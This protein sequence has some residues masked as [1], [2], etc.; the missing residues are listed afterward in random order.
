MITVFPQVFM[1]K[2]FQFCKLLCCAVL[3]RLVVFDSVTPCTIAHQAPLSMGSLKARILEWVGMPSSRGSSQPRNQTQVSHIADRFFTIWVTREAL[4]NFYSIQIDAYFQVGLQS[5]GLTDGV[6]FT[7]RCLGTQY[8][9]LNSY[10]LPTSVSL[11]SEHI[12]PSEAFLFFYHMQP[13]HLLCSISG[14][15]S[16]CPCCHQISAFCPREK[17]H[18]RSSIQEPELQMPPKNAWG[19]ERVILNLSFEAIHILTFAPHFVTLKGKSCNFQPLLITK[20]CVW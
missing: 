16:R 18:A 3:S 19:L 12:N 5:P 11:P 13:T 14:T 17:E 9:P 8:P 2:V 4:V 15:P 10:R 7:P 1:A 20:Q 6:C